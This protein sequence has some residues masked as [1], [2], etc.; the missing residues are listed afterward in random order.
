M[1]RLVVLGI[2]AAL[3][4]AGSSIAAGA[5]VDATPPVLVDVTLSRSL[6][7]VSGLNV[8]LVT[9]SVHLM[10]D[11]GVQPSGDSDN[12]SIRYPG[13]GFSRLTGA[14]KGDWVNLDL[15]SGTA[16][17]GIWSADWPIASTYNGRW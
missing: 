17:D 9:V 12:S 1:R 14:A 11:S 5:P 10:D 3:F 16:T 2:L 4:A 7:T 8:A 13:I 6:V 15:T